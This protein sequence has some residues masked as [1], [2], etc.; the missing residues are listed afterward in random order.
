M[1]VNKQTQRQ[2]GNDAVTQVSLPSLVESQREQ[3]KQISTVVQSS[4]ESKSVTL[5]KGTTTTQTQ[6]AAIGFTLQVTFKIAS[7]A[8]PKLLPKPLP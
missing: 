2:D 1:A 3:P 8:V 4:S 6:K 7:G 5:Q